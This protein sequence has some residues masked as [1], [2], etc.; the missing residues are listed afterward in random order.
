[1]QKEKPKYMEQLNSQN[2]FK[3]IVDYRAMKSE[4]SDPQCSTSL[5]N[6]H[7]PVFKH[8]VITHN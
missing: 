2:M 7:A 8:D 6:T 3:K 1:M 4:N 5:G